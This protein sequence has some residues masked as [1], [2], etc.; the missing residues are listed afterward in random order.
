MQSGVARERAH[1]RPRL[2]DGYKADVSV[3][4]P[5]CRCSSSS[6]SEA[7][8]NSEPLF[9]PCGGFT[10]WFCSLSLSYH[11]HLRTF[12]LFLNLL[13]SFFMIFKRFFRGWNSWNNS[14]SERWNGIFYRLEL[15]LFEHSNSK[16]SYDHFGVEANNFARRW[17]R[18]LYPIAFLSKFDF[19]I[20]YFQPFYKFICYC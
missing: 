7:D 8:A 15:V 19:L 3:V 10:L 4:Q 16:F 1:P 11:V 12:M 5:D 14:H 20:C 17:T 6:T 13:S 18:M 9:L 2:V